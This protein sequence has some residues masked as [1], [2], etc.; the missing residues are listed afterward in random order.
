ML[1][2]F[3]VPHFHLDKNSL[4][5]QIIYLF[6][7]G[8]ISRHVSVVHYP[9]PEEL[10]RRMNPNNPKRNPSGNDRTTYSQPFPKK[11]Y[12]S[13]HA[14]ST[15][16]SRPKSSLSEVGEQSNNPKR[17]RTAESEDYTFELSR[18]H[19]SGIS[20]ASSDQSHGVKSKR[21]SKHEE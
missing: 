15:Q 4:K 21:R 1:S 17:R 14:A 12:G 5:N 13:G 3:Y 18:G 8:M 9:D 16:G 2:L 7:A 10:E 11:S 20:V 19:S 6:T